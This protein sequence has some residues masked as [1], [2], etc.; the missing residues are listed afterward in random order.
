M[1]DEYILV[2]FKIRVL[3]RCQAYI[4]VSLENE[5]LD[6]CESLQYVG[7]LFVLRIKLSVQ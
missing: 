3:G 1:N 5:G 6:V 7:A 4:Q 2:Q